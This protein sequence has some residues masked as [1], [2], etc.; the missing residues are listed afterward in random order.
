MST[1]CPTSSMS[2]WWE[3]MKLKDGLPYWMQS[4]DFTKWGGGGGN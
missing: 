3:L 4:N 2:T 1:S